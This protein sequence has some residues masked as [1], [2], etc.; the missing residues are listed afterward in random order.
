MTEK[1]KMLAGEVYSPFDPELTALHQNALR[2]AER[3]NRES[4]ADCLT[5]N[6]TLRQLLPNTHPSLIVQPPFL[7]DF[8]F[9]IEGGEN[10]FINYNCTILD[11][12]PRPY[13]GRC[14]YCARCLS[15]LFGAFD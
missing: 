13:R 2:I 7:C 1:E 4:F 15:E 9:L 12:S 5:R 3:Y 8:G 14:F 6:D 10:G 11:T